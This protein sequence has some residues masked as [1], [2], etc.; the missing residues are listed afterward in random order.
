M[1][2][3][4]CFGVLYADCHMPTHYDTCHY[5]ECRYVKCRYANGRGAAYIVG[6]L[7]KNN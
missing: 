4:L 6:I 5:T 2:V 7:T 3:L 1:A